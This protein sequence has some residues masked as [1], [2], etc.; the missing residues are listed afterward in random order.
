MAVGLNEA[1]DVLKDAVLYFGDTTTSNERLHRAVKAAGL[2]FCR[3]VPVSVTDKSVSLGSGVGT[4]DMNAEVAG[5]QDPWFIR[6]SISNIPVRKHDDASVRRLWEGGTP[7]AG[8]PTKISCPYPTGWLFDKPTD[9]TSTLVVT[10][11][12]PFTS[13][14]PGTTNNPDLNIPEEYLYDVLHWGALGYFLKGISEQHPEA[15][16]AMQTFHEFIQKARMDYGLTDSGVHDKQ[17]AD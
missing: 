13:F 10:Y 8:R 2:L 11:R 14:S 3:M 6:A 5:W 12:Q 16:S 4:L 15:P 9:T 7:T 1:T 17:V